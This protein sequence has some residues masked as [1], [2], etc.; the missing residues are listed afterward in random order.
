MREEKE[1]VLDVNEET[2]ASYSQI[3]IKH[4]KLMEEKQ[5]I[6]TKDQHLAKTF[7]DLTEKLSKL[8]NQ[9]RGY[10]TQVEEIDW[11]TC[12]LQNQM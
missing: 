11:D 7:K 8:E 2:N 10:Q 3:E 6:I 12:M 1:G 9:R 5:N 4:K